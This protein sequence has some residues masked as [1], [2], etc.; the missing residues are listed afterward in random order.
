R[1]QFLPSVI[2]D[3]N[4][5]TTVPPS[6]HKLPPSPSHLIPGHHRSIPSPSQFTP[7]PS[8]SLSVTPKPLHSLSVFPSPRSALP[9]GVS[10]TPALSCLCQCTPQLISV[11]PP[12]LPVPPTVSILQGPLSSQPG[13]GCLLCFV[14]DFYLAQVQVRWFQ[15]QQELSGHVVATDVVPNGDWSHQLLV[16]L[17]MPP[18]R[19]LGVLTPV[20]PPE[21]PP[22][23]AHSKM[24]T[25]IR[26]FVLGFIV[27]VL[28]LGFYL[29]KKVRGY[30]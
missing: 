5:A 10:A 8:P 26:G 25:G 6:I 18:P 12:S 19:F 27:M 3:D 14:M 13:P 22:D 30:W 11:C 17:K 24:L 4:S 28:E 23:A 1:A 2:L 29:H 9:A 7:R 21:M 16:L 20:D 15:G